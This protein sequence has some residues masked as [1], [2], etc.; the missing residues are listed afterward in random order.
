[1]PAA[2]RPPTCV[3]VE[4]LVLRRLPLLLLALLSLLV[5][6]LAAVRAPPLARLLLHLRQRLLGLL[7]LWGLQGV[8]L[9]RIA[10]RLLRALALHSRPCFGGLVCSL[11][12]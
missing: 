2:A 7:L 1:M 6:R 4:Q 3:R 12:D 11:E 8:V 9:L 5:L 10:R